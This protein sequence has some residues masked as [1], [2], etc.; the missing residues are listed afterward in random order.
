MRILLLGA[1]GQVGFELQRSLSTLGVVLPA[2][3]SGKLP[4][5]RVCALCDL[6]D[7]GA[8]RKLVR[9]SGADWIVNAAAYTAV[10]RAEDEVEIAERINA[11]A[12]ADIAAEA[13]VRGATVVHF[14]TD[15]VFGGSG[16]RPFT[17]DDA[18]APINV[19]GRSKFAGEQALRDAGVRH[20]ILRTAWVYGS[21][22]HN[23]L[24]TMLKLAATR[25][26]L[27]VVNDQQGTP[28]TARLLADVVTSAMHDLRNA[29]ADDPRF[30]TYHVTAAGSTT[31]HG[32][33]SAIVKSARKAGLISR[34]I[35]VDPIASADFPT[36]AK[37]P[38]WSVLDCAK[39][40]RTFGIP[41]PDWRDGLS[42]T[43]AEIVEAR[44][45]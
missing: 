45:K 24:L 40:M 22:G 23:F 10:D 3:L 31:W 21:R 42:A 17:E 26:R 32:F 19:Y 18:A 35:A 36:K 43:M 1:D 2:T 7:S 27:T 6:I 38:T 37:R 28:T 8:T 5:G 9:E 12:L 20:L 13:K 39:L 41:L 25:D 14:S 11:A 15:Y 44:K 29:A 34:D 33:A 30:G 16:N 4:D